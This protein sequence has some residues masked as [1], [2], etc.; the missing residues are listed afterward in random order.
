MFRIAMLSAALLA[1]GLAGAAHA[2]DLQVVNQGEQFEVH[3]PAGYTG[4]I[5]G[6]GAVRVSGQ[7]ESQ[8]IA[9]LTASF[10]QQP[11]GI[12]VFVGGGEGR[13][14]YLPAAQGQFLANR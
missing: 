5:L 11:A 7:G 1:S 10:A 12:P 4:N 14:A 3:Y 9:H 13:V 8:R 6:G 2:Q